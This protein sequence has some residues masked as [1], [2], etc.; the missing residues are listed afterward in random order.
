MSKACT[1]GNKIFRGFEFSGV[2]MAIHE[3]GDG[4]CGP[5]AYGASS[6]VFLISFDEL[7]FQ[8]DYN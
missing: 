6:K 4:Y 8:V 7:L 1:V 5:V 2:S 3:V